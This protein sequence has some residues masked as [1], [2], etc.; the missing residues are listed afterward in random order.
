MIRIKKFLESK[1]P[2]EI[3]YCSY[4]WDDNILHM[5]TKI[6]LDHL[7]NGE[8][9]EESV[10]TAKFAEVRTDKE[11]WRVRD[12]SFS[13]FKDDGPRGEFAFL[14]DVKEAIKNEEYG[15]S[16]N[17]FIEYLSNGTIFAI[18]TAR[19]H[20][21]NSIRIAVE[22]IIDNVLSENQKHLLYSHCLKF[23]Y[24]F[25]TDYDSYDRI[26]K[27]QLSKT[28]LIGDYLDECDFYG[29][30]SK[31]CITKF[32]LGNASN[33]EKGKELAIKEFTKKVHSYGEKIGG[34]VSLGFS[35]DDLKN[36]E[37]IE[38]VFRNELALTYAL[39]YT[40]FDTSKRHIKGGIKRKISHSNESQSSFGSG[41]SSIGLDS[42]VIPFTK[43][44]NMTQNLYPNGDQPLDDYHNQFKN[45]IGQLKDLQKKSN[46][47]PKKRRYKKIIKKNEKD[48]NI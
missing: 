32:G 26:P 38:K 15:P 13:E 12:N 39:K 30:S 9:V 21:P 7:V 25:N 22:W 37:H 34:R 46:L 20:E 23:A 29:V 40:I 41:M 33:P 48:S 2:I 10:S 17:S 43:W 6:H 18:I 24:L 11:N 42:S 8:W 3:S 16:W 5:P 19:G 31:Y 14:E 35:D 27:G 28:N 47:K 1:D 36:I 4:D 44:N 45:Q